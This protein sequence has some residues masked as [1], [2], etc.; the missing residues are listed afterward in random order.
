MEKTSRL[1]TTVLRQFMPKEVFDKPPV[2][3]AIKEA[4]YV[5]Q[6][7]QISNV[8]DSGIKSEG[9]CGWVKDDIY[10]DVQTLQFHGNFQ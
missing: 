9:V 7:S 3:D 6:D 10:K 8:E 5:Y 1:R 4:C 2:K